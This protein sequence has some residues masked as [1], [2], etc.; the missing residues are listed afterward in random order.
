MKVRDHMTRDVITARRTANIAEIAELLKRNRITGVPIVDE[1][2]RLVGVVT[3]EELMKVFIP[4]YLS[5]F[6]E[7]GFV[8]DLGAIEAQTMAEIEPS[9]FLADDVMVADPIT[10]R[11]ETSIMKVAALMA[12][13]KLVLVPVVD[14]SNR[15]VGV[16]NRSD[17]SYA[18]T[19]AAS[20]EEG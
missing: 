14:E 3:H 7:L 6:D 15:L 5:M 18:F 11:P 8:D 13:M 20:K 1:E 12:N 10:V 4:H 17:V 2:N 19:G 16:M 9:L